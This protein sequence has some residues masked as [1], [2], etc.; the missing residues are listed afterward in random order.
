L[1][2]RVTNKI[3]DAIDVKVSIKGDEMAI[4]VFGARERVGGMGPGR[5]SMALS[6]LWETPLVFF[7]GR[8][9]L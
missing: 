4:G 1:D 3:Q 8:A 9:D 5:S 7:G 6:W 2:C